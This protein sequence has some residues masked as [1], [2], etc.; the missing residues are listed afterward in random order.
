[1]KPFRTCVLWSGSEMRV[2]ISMLWNCQV[3]RFVV[4]QNKKYKKMR[5]SEIVFFSYLFLNLMIFTMPYFYIRSKKKMYKLHFDV[6]SFIWIVLDFDCSQIC[7]VLL[8]YQTNIS[9]NPLTWYL[10]RSVPSLPISAWDSLDSS[11][12]KVVQ[13]SI[14]A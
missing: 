1:M 10:E 13:F 11:W 12:G 14:Q 6:K 4:W 3:I 9:L 8:E 7:Y 2:T 5:S